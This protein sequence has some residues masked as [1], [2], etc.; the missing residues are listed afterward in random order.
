M[1]D[2]TASSNSWNGGASILIALSP[3]TPR[4]ALLTS[5][6]LPSTSLQVL[7]PLRASVHA[8]DNYPTHIYEAI[9]DC[10]VAIS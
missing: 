10:T 5:L 9:E 4:R 6:N 8:L 7:S 2:R 3:P 1:V